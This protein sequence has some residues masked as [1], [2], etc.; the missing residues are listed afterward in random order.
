MT[1]ERPDPRTGPAGIADLVEYQPDAVVSRVV[2]KTPAGSVTVF[3]FDAGQSLSEHRVPHSVL[4]HALDGV[5]E[6]AVDGVPHRLRPG[7]ALLMA[8]NAAHTVHAPEP[9][10]MI[11][12]MLRS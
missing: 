9:F 3:A 2:L 11:L 10:K 7:D 8:P 4:V 1:D 12:T 6:L 5:V